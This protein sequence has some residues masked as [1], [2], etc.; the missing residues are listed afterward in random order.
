[1]KPEKKHFQDERECRCGGGHSTDW[2]D[3]Y[4][5]GREDGFDEGADWGNG[6]PGTYCEQCN[7]YH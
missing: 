5:A 4:E 7:D 6:P 1:M 2:W 3:G